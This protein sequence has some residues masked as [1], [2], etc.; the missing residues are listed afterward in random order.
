MGLYTYAVDRL[1]N[2]VFS[3]INT[4]DLSTLEVPVKIKV[5][6]SHASL[7]TL[8]RHCK[9]REAILSILQDLEGISP[10]ILNEVSYTNAV[11]GP[12]PCS[13]REILTKI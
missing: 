10:I 7:N 5:L 4:L 9:F 8:G 3:P 13:L 1:T 12:L 11:E 6:P 2:A